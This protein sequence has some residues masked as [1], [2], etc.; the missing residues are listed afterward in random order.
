MAL[1]TSGISFAGIAS[2]LDSTSIIEALMKLRHRPIDV[3]AKRKSGF[4]N[5]Q[6]H[7]NQLRELVSRVR[8]AVDA[9][10]SANEFGAFAA[11]SSAESVLTA[12]AT[13][14]ASPGS[15][16]VTVGALAKA[17][18]EASNGYADGT[19]TS[20]GTGDITLTVGGVAKT[21]TIASGE[22][23]LE[24][25]RDAINNAKAGVS[26][27]VV[28]TGT[29]ATPYKLVLQASATGAANSIS[30]DLSQF[31]GTLAFTQQQAASDA[32]VTV[33]GITASRATNVI[34]DFVSGVTL[35]LS[36]VG[37]STITLTP[38]VAK[39]RDKV[40]AYVDAQ[41]ALVNFVNAEMKYNEASKSAGPLAADVS[42]RLLLN[43]LG[44]AHSANGYPGGSFNVLSQVGISLNADGTVKFDS[45][46]FDAA[47]ADHAQD[48]SQLFTTVGDR[49]S[50]EGFSIVKVH[51][52]VAAGNYAVNVTQAATRAETTIATAF[53]GGGALAQ[54]EKLT[55]TQGAKT[56]SVDLK[57]G[58]T[59][60]QAITKIRGAAGA[61]G[62]KLI[63]SDSGGSLNI[64]A[65]GY[66]S[67]L[68]FSVVSDQAAG[69]TTSGV[70]TTAVV[71]AGQDVQGTIG[72]L[73]A[74]GAGQTLTGSGALA[75]VAIN[76]VG[77]TVP[78]QSTLTVG[79]DGF[80]VRMKGLL[81]GALN[82]ADGTLTTR[83][84]GIQKSI[85]GIDKNITSL[86]SRLDDYEEMLE[87]RFSQLEAII[88]NIK[89]AQS[90][91]ATL[92]SQR[93]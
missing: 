83:L 41:N 51:D 6:A 48:L 89:T 9:I 55:F 73:A 28:N 38:D 31:T 81:D 8:T 78:A 59:L 4:Q 68:G 43:S 17:E 82:A 26:A 62:A 15:F 1:S 14:S 34:S 16:T 46:K 84:N 77:T 10:N 11:A 69:P 70:G 7:L 45:E 86:E 52:G 44:R 91:V 40:K 50:G 20:V 61:K 90:Y 60:A 21:I 85:A 3:L 23:T 49:V 57:T 92:A 56:F 47:A 32:S 53:A 87:K 37:T 75:K 33:N 74:T 93:F 71:A 19:T 5:Q 54:D 79:P 39:M 64:R 30:V 24:K 2:G 63:V 29:G 76:Y 72:G 80:F 67:A 88:G 65:D 13:G 27:T 36:D 25:V 18:V 42:T 35:T 22:D 58:D 12:T 66:G